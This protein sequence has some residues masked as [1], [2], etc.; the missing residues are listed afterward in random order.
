MLAY[1]DIGDGLPLVLLHGISSSR[2]RWTPIID[3]LTPDRRCIAVDLPG[4]GDSPPEGCDALSAAIAV[5]ELVRLLELDTPTVIGHSLGASIAL[6]YAALFTPASVIAIDPTPLH[7][8]DVAATLAPYRSRLQG[9]DFNAAFLEWEKAFALRDVPEPLRTNLLDSMEPRRDVVLSYWS[10]LLR[11]GGA[12]ELQPGLDESL[13]SISVPVLA[14]L[15]HAPGE[16]DAAIL[17]RMAT[18]RIEIFE[19]GGHYLHLV[20]PPAFATRV[21]RWTDSLPSSPGNERPQRHPSFE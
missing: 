9:D 1:D 18:T 11:P 15:P 6:L 4:H 5:H 20:D 16:A 21:R 17:R 3:E 19:Q 14:C 7:L 12:A 10:T 2:S 13:S 8:P